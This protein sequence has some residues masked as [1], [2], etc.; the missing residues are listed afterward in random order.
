MMAALTPYDPAR[1]VAAIDIIRTVFSG[2]LP[3]SGIHD[4]TPIFV[5]GMPRSGS[6]LVEQMLGSHSRVRAAAHTRV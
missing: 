1:D 5:V 3:D 4:A 6:T 2:P